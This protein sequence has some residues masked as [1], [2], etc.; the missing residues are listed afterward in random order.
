M[1]SAFVA[2]SLF[3]WFRGVVHK[4]GVS[5]RVQPTVNRGMDNVQVYN[6]YVIVY[7]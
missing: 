2:L 3:D 6:I 7:K 1:L 4:T 5:C